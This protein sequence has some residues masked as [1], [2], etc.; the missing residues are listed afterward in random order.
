MGR[1]QFRPWMRVLE[2]IQ[3]WGIRRVTHR[4]PN[5]AQ[6]MPS[7]MGALVSKTQINPIVL[8]FPKTQTQG[9]MV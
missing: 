5:D 9:L 1:K 8:H 6:I 7:A 3:Y 4:H 2:P